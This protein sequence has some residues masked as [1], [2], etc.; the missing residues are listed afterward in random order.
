MDPNSARFACVRLPRSAY[1]PPAVWRSP[2]RSFSATECIRGTKNRAQ[3][4]GRLPASI[5]AASAFSSDAKRNALRQQAIIKWLDAEP[6]ARQQQPAPI[7]VP[8]R[9][10][11]HADELRQTCAAVAAQQV[12]QHFGV[13]GRVPGTRQAR[14][15]RLVI[16]EFA[17]VGEHVAPVDHRL[18]SRFGEVEDREPAMG[19]RHPSRA[20][21]PLAVGPRCCNRSDIRPTV[22]RLALGPMIPAIPH[23]ARSLTRP[24]ATRGALYF[25]LPAGRA[26]QWAALRLGCVLEFSNYGNTRRPTTAGPCREM[27]E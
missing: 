27:V 14:A 19:K 22:S 9:E 18:M 24:R 20:P 1:V 12:Q 21:G 5:V 7:G 25:T 2:R 4:C 17:V 11:E 8:V 13:P 15:Q 26:S 16:V 10:R 3:R 6:V 23:M